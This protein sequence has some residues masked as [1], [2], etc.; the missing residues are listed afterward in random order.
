MKLNHLNKNTLSSVVVGS[1]MLVYL[2]LD[3]PLPFTVVLGDFTFIILTIVTLIASCFIYQLTNIFVAVIYLVVL[4]ELIKK[5]KLNNI[6]IINNRNSPATKNY[7]NKENPEV[8][9]SNN[10]DKSISLEEEMVN[11]ILPSHSHSTLNRTDRVQPLL[12]D[13]SQSL[14]ISN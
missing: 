4:Y 13:L 9:I 5:V 12:P 10:F 1:I 3:T 2:Y 6:N 7:Y 14:E 8:V 11:N